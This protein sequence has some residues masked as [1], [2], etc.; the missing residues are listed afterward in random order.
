[1]VV[2]VSKVRRGLVLALFG[3]TSATY[4]AEGVAQGAPSLSLIG[5]EAT[6]KALTS[7]R[8]SSLS[9]SRTSLFQMSR[10]SRKSSPT[11]PAG[12]LPSQCAV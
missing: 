5:A 4:F 12:S 6:D 8:Q 11:L 1:V 7:R 9:L 2:K 3:L 10:S